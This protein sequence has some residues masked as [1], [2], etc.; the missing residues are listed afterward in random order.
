MKD[1]C[2]G[3]KYKALCKTCPQDFSCDDVK[4]LADVQPEKED[5]NNDQT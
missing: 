2:S 4:R 3:C 5:T 1:L